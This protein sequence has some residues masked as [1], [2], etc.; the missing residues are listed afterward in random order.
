M[1]T[2][3]NIDWQKLAYR[4]WLIALNSA[5]SLIVPLF[6]VLIS[7]LVV[8]R[9]SAE[10]WGEFVSYLIIVQLAAHVMGWGNKEYLLREFSINP[11]DLC[12]QWQSI[13]LT[14][15]TL[16]P[17]FLI[18]LYFIGGPSVR[19]LT[20]ALWTFAL[21]WQQS[22]DVVILYR[23]SFLFALVTE[24][25]PVIIMVAAIWQYAPSLTVDHLLRWFALAT[26][27]KVISYSLYFRRILWTAW[28]GKLTFAYF[29]LA[30]SFFLLGFSGMVQSRV[31]LY[32]VNI[33]LTAQELAQYQ[34][35]IGFM[36]YLQSL[37][38]LI[39]MPFVKRVY[40]LSHAHIL[41]LARRLLLLGFV[42]VPLGLLLVWQVMV[43]I[44]DFN[45]S[46]L[47]YA[48]GAAYVIPI[49]FSVPIIYSLYKVNR[50]RVVLT[51]NVVAI[52]GNFML[53]LLLIPIFGMLGALIATT[54][55][56]FCTVTVYFLQSAGL[57]QTQPAAKGA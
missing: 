36:L 40:S 57:R 20:L 10:L 18:V 31:D 24:I 29:S 43:R 13:L 50:Q 48:W 38:A 45:L 42:I 22:Y 8:R 7:L 2:L 4:V 19:L 17:L 34:V 56:R 12:L 30:I 53:N 26:A 25:T 28:Q 52:A 27:A 23:R 9:V 51:V 1:K 21:V 44:Y 16:F 6:T 32:S 37:A 41:Q 5:N 35:F 15:L 33:L 47:F 49:Y 54:L 39:I 14:R 3:A 55:I 46:W 11:T